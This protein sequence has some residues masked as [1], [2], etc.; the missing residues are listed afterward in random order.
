MPYGYGSAN[1]GSRSSGPGPGGQGARGQATQNPGR[2]GGWSPGAGGKQHQPKKKTSTWTPGA[3]GKQHIPKKK[4]KTGGGGG[5]TTTTGGASPFTYTKT[6]KGRRTTGI[7][8][9]NKFKKWIAKN[10]YNIEPWE[11]DVG[12]GLQ[13][14]SNMP[15]YWALPTNLKKAIDTGKNIPFA[16]GTKTLDDY[17]N[18]SKTGFQTARTKVIPTAHDWANM[19]KGK[20]PFK[21]EGVFGAVGDD[22]LKSATKYAQG[23]MLRGSPF[24]KTTGKVFEGAIDPAT[25]YINRGLSG[26]IQA[27]VPAHIANKAFN[28]PG[29]V[30]TSI[31]ALAEPGFHKI[32]KRALPGANIALGGASALGHLQKGNYGQAAMAGLSM[33]PGPVGWAGLGG[34][35]A[36]GALQNAKQKRKYANGG[37]IDLYRYGGFSG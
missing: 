31:K 14:V 28:L 21:A 15:K 37:L 13:F 18:L 26:N 6:P 17:A 5:G 10:K 35:L 22:A 3:G 7:T 27:R 8:D 33:V 30:S 32:A 29:K 23:A 36:L 20:N 16:H 1:R 4:T 2:G 19:L 25:A 12:S 34:E 9:T 11:E 24:G